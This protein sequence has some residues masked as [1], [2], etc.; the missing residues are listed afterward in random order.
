MATFGGGLITGCKS[1]VYPKMEPTKLEHEKNYILVDSKPYNIAVR[2]KVNSPGNEM[3]GQNKSLLEGTIFHSKRLY[4]YPL[5]RMLNHGFNSAVDQCFLKY[6]GDLSSCYTLIVEPHVAMLKVGVDDEVYF[7]MSA[8]V[9]FK[10]PG[11]KMLFSETVEK[12]MVKRYYSEERVLDVICDV[13]KYLSKKTVKDIVESMEFQ[14][15]YVNRDQKVTTPKKLTW[16]A[17]VA[18]KPQMKLPKEE[19]SFNSQTKLGR[20]AI[21]GKGLDA[22][23]YLIKRIGEICSSTGLILKAG[24]A[25]PSGYFRI[26]KEELKDGNL[27]IDFQ[28]R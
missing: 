6:N 23:K 2:V 5:D 14:N 19:L 13:I 18:S 9:G 17:I 26:L 8:Y 10:A 1:H 20:I 11:G 7:K 24:Q 21:T 25:P 27:I 28:G 15:H 16:Q 3:I 22:R 12:S 4:H